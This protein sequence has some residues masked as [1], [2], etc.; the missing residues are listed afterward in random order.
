M[1]PIVKALGAL[2]IASALTL[3][4]MVPSSADDRWAY[5]A[6][7]FAAGAFLGAAAANANRAY[8]GSPYGYAYEP[9]YAAPAY[10]Y[11][12]SEP[13]YVD[14]YAYAPAYRTYVGPRYRSCYNNRDCLPARERALRGVD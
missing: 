1:R 3:S 13:A 6:G 9:Y 10:T 8:Y 2:G 4:A 11:S 12:Y 14:T 7:G 5:A